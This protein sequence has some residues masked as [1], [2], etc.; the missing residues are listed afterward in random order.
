[1][2]S[3]ELVEIKNDAQIKITNKEKDEAQDE[4]FERIAS[5]P[6]GESTLIDFQLYRDVISSL[7]YFA[8]KVSVFTNSFD[9]YFAYE[10]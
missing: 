4:S 2:H 9:S 5:A 7:N 8:L 3:I 1:M 10:L 6:L